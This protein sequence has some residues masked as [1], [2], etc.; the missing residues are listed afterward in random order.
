MRRKKSGGSGKSKSALSSDLQIA[1]KIANIML[2]NASRL[3]LN[4]ANLR[5]STVE[6][7]NK[8]VKLRPLK[9]ENIEF[10]VIPSNK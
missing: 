9:V 10:I 6:V 7:I 5:S 8:S 3:N 1:N 4:P 2:A